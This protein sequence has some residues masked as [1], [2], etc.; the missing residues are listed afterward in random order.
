MTT[1]YT[2]L[3]VLQYIFLVYLGVSA[4]YFFLYAFIAQFPRKRK[5]S[6]SDKKNKFVVLIPGY[7]EDQVIIDVA[8]E[9]LKQDYPNELYD[10]VVIADSFKEETVAKLKE[11]PIIVNEVFFEVS[12]KSKSINATLASLPNNKY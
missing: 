12:S 7:K 3:K 8:A 10:I 2:I 11:L 1:L 9:A 6:Q 5:I 4:I